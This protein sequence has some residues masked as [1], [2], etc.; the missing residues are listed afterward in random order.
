LEVRSLQDCYVGDHFNVEY[1]RFYTKFNYK[2]A[3]KILYLKIFKYKESIYDINLTNIYFVSQLL[4]FQIGQRINS[5][6]VTDFHFANN[7]LTQGIEIKNS[8]LFLKKSLINLKTNMMI[9]KQQ[10][11]K[12]ENN[13]KSFS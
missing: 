13:I 1:M 10:K 5:F 2:M 3:N 11:D 7:K 12:Y 6:M 9:L 4:F 8:E